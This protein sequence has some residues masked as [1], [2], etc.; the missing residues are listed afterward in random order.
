[1]VVDAPPRDHLPWEYKMRQP[2]CLFCGHGTSLRIEHSD[3]IYTIS[4]KCESCDAQSSN[5]PTA[6]D[7][8]IAAASLRALALYDRAHANRR[9]LIATVE[10]QS[11][12]LC[13]LWHECLDTR[14]ESESTIFA[15]LNAF[16]ALNKWQR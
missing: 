16:A 10:Q 3:G 6:M 4:V 11:R 9:K 8:D 15:A 1:M 2:T 7:E 5:G 14:I 12:L 13:K